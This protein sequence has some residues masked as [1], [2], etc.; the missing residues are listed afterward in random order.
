MNFV[1]PL[2]CLRASLGPAD[3]NPQAVQ[4]SP[5]FWHM[6]VPFC[7]GSPWK[8]VN[9]KKGFWLQ[10]LGKGAEGVQSM[11]LSGMCIFGREGTVFLASVN[12][13]TTALPIL[14]GC[15]IADG[16]EL[17]CQAPDGFCSSG[18]RTGTSGQA[19]A[20]MCSIDP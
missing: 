18:E 12:V 17:M 11:A 19:E 20:Y 3:S 8:M 7:A 14:W 16:D 2:Y 15:Q 6:F 1:H 13:E 9:A 10:E 4:C 5:A